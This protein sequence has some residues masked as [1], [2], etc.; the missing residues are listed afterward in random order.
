MARFKAQ[1]RGHARRPRPELGVGR[2]ARRRCPPARRH[3]SCCSSPARTSP[4]CCSRAP[5][6]ARARWRV[7]LSIGASRWQLVRQL[8][9]ESMVLA[10]ARRARGP[11]GRALDARPDRVDPAAEDAAESL[12]LAIDRPVLLFTGAVAIV[13][14]V[15]FGLFPALHSTRPDLLPLAQGASGPA[16]GVT[17]PRCASGSS[18][19]TAQIALSM[20]LLVCA[21]LFAQSL[22][23]ISRVDLGLEVDNLVT[24]GVSPELNG[25]TPA[26]SRPSSSVLEDDLGAMPGVTAVGGRSSRCSRGQQLGHRRER[27]RGSR[28]GPTSTTTR[29]STWWVPATSGPWA[30]RSSPAASSRAPTSW[31]AKVAIVNEAFAKK[32]N[33]GRDAVGKRMARNGGTRA[34]HRDRRPRAGREVQ[35]GQA[36]GA[37]ALLPPVAPGRRRSGR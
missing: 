35:R 11:A 6:P 37:A 19:A 26:K 32:F 29:A 20:A 36:A 27:R 33:L 7:R 34:R 22:V 9:T 30:C 8:L 25:Y 4:T 5:R 28:P 17:R 31:A 13:T 1:G 10:A 15:L 3:G 2:G 14:G 23:N 24:F 18:L 12:P 16:V 21:G